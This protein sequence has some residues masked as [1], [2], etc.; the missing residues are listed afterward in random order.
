MTVPVW[1]WGDDVAPL[2]ACVDRGGVVAIPTESSYGLAAD[3]LSAQGCQAIREIKGRPAAEPLPVV[4]ES[5]E[6]ASRLGISSSAP[7]LEEVSSHW[8]KALTFVTPVASRLPAC[9]DLDSLAFRIPEHPRLRE[10]LR[11]L[12]RALTATSANRGGS[13][14][15][16][17]TKPL[18]KLLEGRDAY[19][20]D[21]GDLPG[22][23]PSTLVRWTAEGFEV[24]RCGSVLFVPVQSRPSTTH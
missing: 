13:S 11:Q 14:P 24:L 18:Q 2:A 15:I 16:T 1:K 23:P 20:V 3:P 12:G 8:P 10:L 9:G 5:V 6:Q 7:G 17:S 22:G 19:I 4:A 21:D